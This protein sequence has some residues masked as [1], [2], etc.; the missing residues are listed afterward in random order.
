MA[1]TLM[2]VYALII[3][4]SLFLVVISRQTDIPCKSDDACPRV[5]S[6]HIECVKGFCTYWKLD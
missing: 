5:S 6:H 3:F 1:Q 2:L 4:T